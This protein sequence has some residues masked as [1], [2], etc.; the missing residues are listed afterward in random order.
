MCSIPHKGNAISRAAILFLSLLMKVTPSSMTHLPMVVLAAETVVS[1][2]SF[3]KVL[4]SIQNPSPRK[5]ECSPYTFVFLFIFIFSSFLLSF[6]HSLDLILQP[7]MA[8]SCLTLLNAGVTG[9]MPI[10]NVH[11]LNPESLAFHPCPRTSGNTCLIEPLLYL[12]P[13]K[14][15]GYQGQQKAR[16][17]RRRLLR[18]G[19]HTRRVWALVGR[20][21]SSA[22]TP[23]PMTSTLS[24]PTYLP[25]SQY[26]SVWSREEVG[27]LALLLKSCVLLGKCLPL[28]GLSAADSFSGPLESAGWTWASQSMLSV[29]ICLCLTGKLHFCPLHRP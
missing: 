6:W 8:T 18:W 7:K 26:S 25:Y 21:R 5:R 20:Q 29:M 13:C 17:T 28:S 23:P 14:G 16:E 1:A 15:S 24:S 11:F 10:V 9:I 3:Q 22:F 12:P 2:M 4:D 19:Y 27:F